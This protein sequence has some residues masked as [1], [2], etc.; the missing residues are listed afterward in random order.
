LHSPRRGQAGTFS[1]GADTVSPATFIGDVVI[2]VAGSVA[3]AGVVDSPFAAKDAEMARGDTPVADGC[4]C[5]V[6]LTPAWRRKL[7]VH[8]VTEASVFE[9]Q[10]GRWQLDLVGPLDIALHEFE[11]TIGSI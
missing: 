10:V 5:L 7:T 4:I 8:F 9:D 3:V 2:A 6:P 11:A 1:N